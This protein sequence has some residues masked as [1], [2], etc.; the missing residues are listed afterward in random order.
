MLQALMIV[1]QKL[2]CYTAF[3]GD[4]YQPSYTYTC[5]NVPAFNVELVY[6]YGLLMAEQM[7][8]ATVRSA[9]VS[10]IKIIAPRPS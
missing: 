10:A 9:G 3:S 2:T 6:K 1:Q 7:I 4:S 8:I 5:D